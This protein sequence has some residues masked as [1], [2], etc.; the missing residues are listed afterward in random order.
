MVCGEGSSSCRT[1]NSLKDGVRDPVHL[2]VQSL[3]LC[4][5]SRLRFRESRPKRQAS[6]IYMNH[7]S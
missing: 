7:L 4:G 3:R 6:I 5:G 1:Q 2:A